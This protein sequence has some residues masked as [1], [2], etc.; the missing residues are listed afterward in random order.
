MQ[1]GTQAGG[2]P[3]LEINGVAN[4]GGGRYRNVK[5]DGVGSVTG[6]VKAVDFRL[7]GVITLKGVLEA[8]HLDADGKLKVEGSL[9][10]GRAELD[11][12]VDVMG[13]VKGEDLSLNG[14]MN[15]RGDCA[16]ERLQAEGGFQIDGLLNAGSIQLTLHG[17]SK[18]TRSTWN[19]RKY[20]SSGE[21]ASSSVPAAASAGSSIGAS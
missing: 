6:D 15:V 9:A 14:L 8:G 1:T 2:W 4:A 11:G 3:D 19:T 12:L 5:I 20:P 13:T 16:L 18:A 10:A 21:T 7:N 17:R